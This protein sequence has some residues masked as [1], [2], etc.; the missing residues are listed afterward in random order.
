MRA[1]KS[2]Q[3]KLVPFDND[4]FDRNNTGKSV[5]NNVNI[6]EAAITISVASIF[7]VGNM[8]VMICLGQGGL[9]SLSASSLQLCFMSELFAC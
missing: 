2:H 6:T 3:V 4:T 7:T 5:C 9:R 1:Q 8:G